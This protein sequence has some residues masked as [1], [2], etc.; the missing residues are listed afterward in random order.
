[1]AFNVHELKVDLSFAQDL[2]SLGDGQVSSMKRLTVQAVMHAC[3]L[4]WLLPLL[5]LLLHCTSWY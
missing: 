3:L 1:M 4:L 5:P 2:S